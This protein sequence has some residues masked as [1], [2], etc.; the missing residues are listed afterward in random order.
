MERIKVKI[1]VKAKDESKLPDWGLGKGI[2][3]EQEVILE[4]TPTENNKIRLALKLEEIYND[5]LET[6]LEKVI[7]VEN[8]I[9]KD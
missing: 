5:L 6:T 9:N 1:K 7:E 8:E 4:E 2:L 3:A